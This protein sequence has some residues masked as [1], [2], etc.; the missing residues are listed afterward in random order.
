ME[1][2]YQDESNKAIINRISRSIG[3]FQAVK[4][5]VEEG[6]E[7][8]EILIQLS[9]VRAEINGISKAVLKDHLDDCIDNAV[10]D[11][12]AIDGLKE[13]IDQLL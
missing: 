12:A 10:K 13:T 6:R 2:N 3:H 5:M 9:A 8:T 7:R 4:R 11:A 1:Q